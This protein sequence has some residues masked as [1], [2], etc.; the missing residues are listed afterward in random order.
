MFF[1]G[2]ISLVMTIMDEKNTRKQIRNNKVTT[3]RRVTTW[4]NNM[5]QLKELQNKKYY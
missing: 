5:R 4:Q 3:Q 2:F 1:G